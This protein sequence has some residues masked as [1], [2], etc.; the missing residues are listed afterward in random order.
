MD[1]IDL[2]QDT[3]RWRDFVNE[4]MKFVSHKM[5]GIS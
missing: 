4:L 2:P 5:R 1:W 3:E